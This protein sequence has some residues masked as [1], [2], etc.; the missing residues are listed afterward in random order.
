MAIPALTDY[1]MPSRE[2]FPGNRVD[3]Q[4]NPDRAVLLIHDMQ[5]YFLNFYPS[6]S[7]LVQQLIAN[8]VTLRRWCKERGIPVVYTAQPHRQSSTE[9]ALLNDMWGAGLTNAPAELEAITEALAPD[10]GDTVLVKWRY[11][12]FQRSDLQQRLQHWQRDQLLIGGIYAHIG[13][14]VTAADAFMND[15]QPFLVGDAVAD[16]SEADHRMALRYVATRCGSVVSFSD[17]VGLSEVIVDR[18]QQLSRH[19]LEAQLLQLI[20]EETTDLNPDENLIHY[21]LESIQVMNLAIKLKELGVELRFEELA[22]VPTLSGMWA[23]IERKRQ[24][25]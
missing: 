18:S 22:R 17:V 10:E 25:A 1:L 8:L 19:W 20:D 6:D 4:F 11:S 14:M 9:R 2:S 16:F 21:G 24:A 12:A 7:A 3:W 13:C 5:R 15:I 23:V